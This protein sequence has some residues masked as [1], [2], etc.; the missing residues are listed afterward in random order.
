MSW[1]IV[2]KLTGEA[3]LETFIPEVAAAVNQAK[4]EAID[5]HTYLCNLNRNIRLEHAAKGWLR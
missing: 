4:Y 2:N 5:A 1:V 3:V